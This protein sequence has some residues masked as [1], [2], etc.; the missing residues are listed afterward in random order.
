MHELKIE[1]HEEAAA[2]KWTLKCS[3]GW[4]A[5]CVSK[6]EAELLRDLHLEYVGATSRGGSDI[7]GGNNERNT[8]T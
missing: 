1:Y 7:S 4:D 2:R 5:M 3:C 8:E 6:E